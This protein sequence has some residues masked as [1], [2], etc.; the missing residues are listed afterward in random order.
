MY[1]VYLLIKL[2]A[3]WNGACVY[4][5]F[6]FFVTML[7]AYVPL[8]LLDIDRPHMPPSGSQFVMDLTG[9]C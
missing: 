3:S 7:H 5:V 2:P 6:A 1:L 8:L 4:L 9:F